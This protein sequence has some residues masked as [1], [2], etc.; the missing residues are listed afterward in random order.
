MKL[1]SAY[2]FFNKLEKDNMSFLYQGYFSDDLTDKIININEVHIDKTD[3]IT[4]IKSKVSFLLAECFQNIV[5][6]GDE[7]ELT[8]SFVKSS[9]FGTRNIENT[10]SITSA[11][12]IANTE[13]K[14]LVD[15]LEKV[16]SLDKED[17]KALYID[18][19]NN[20]GLSKKGGAG[21]GLV[22][23]ARRSGRKLEYDFRV[24]NSE[25]S[26]FYLQVKHRCVLK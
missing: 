14:S 19:L 12:Q 20:T 13:I 25:Y 11:N 26:L 22:E 6:H 10:Y 18:L 7:L 17:L 8:D 16:N 1:K 21:L 24:I 23:M 4:P 2:N 3:E 9:F 5:R 15:K